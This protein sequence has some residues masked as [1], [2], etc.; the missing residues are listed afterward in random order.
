[1]NRGVS[2]GN[3]LRILLSELNIPREEVVVFGNGLNDVSMFEATGYSVALDNSPDEVKK[4]AD[5]VT[6]FN[7]EDGVAYALQMLFE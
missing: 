1:M 3:A 7:A 6:K 2:K 4:R 5:F